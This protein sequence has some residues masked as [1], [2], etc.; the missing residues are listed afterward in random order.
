MSRRPIRL[1]GP[2]GLL[3]AVGCSGPPESSNAPL[4]SAR[5]RILDADLVSRRYTLY[6]RR[7]TGAWF[8]GGGKDAFGGAA[9]RPMEMTPRDRETIAELMSSAGWIDGTIEIG[10]GTGPR[11]LEVSLSEGIPNT[12][13]SLLATDGRFDSETEALLAALQSIVEREYRGVLD[14]LP[15]ASPSQP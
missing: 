5:I 3:L 6:V 1:L 2:I 15:Q 13:F 4:G 11:H 10:V 12:K 9:P 7:G 8:H 14:A